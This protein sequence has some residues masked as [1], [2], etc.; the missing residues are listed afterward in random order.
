[1]EDPTEELWVGY[2]TIPLDEDNERRFA[3][4]G[5]ILARFS[6]TPIGSLTVAQVREAYL[7][8]KAQQ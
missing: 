6:R 5:E 3:E 7:A 4:Y 8:E 2:D 1:M